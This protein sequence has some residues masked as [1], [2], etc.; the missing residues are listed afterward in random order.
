[1]T[2]FRSSYITAQYYTHMKYCLLKCSLYH[3]C[4]IFEFCVSNIGRVLLHVMCL[5]PAVSGWEGEGA[6]SSVADGWSVIYCGG[7]CYHLRSGGEER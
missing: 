5:V 1:M 2:S 4:K 3:V 6:V 7:S